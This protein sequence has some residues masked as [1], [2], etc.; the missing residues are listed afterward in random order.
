MN[1]REMKQTYRCSW[2]DTWGGRGAVPRQAETWRRTLWVL[3]SPLAF[4]SRFFRFE[5]I[6]I[7]LANP[8]GVSNNKL[9][10]SAILGCGAHDGAIR[11]GYLF[12]CLSRAHDAYTTI[13]V[14]IFQ[15]LVS[16]TWT[17]PTMEGSDDATHIH[18]RSKVTLVS[19]SS[20]VGVVTSH[21]VYGNWLSPSST[22]KRIKR[23]A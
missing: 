14:N 13:A 15:T 1:E 18:Q 19:G 10:L 11:A 3:A 5:W 4:E 9:G 12:H 22:T 23:S 7:R 16:V 8:R 6:G 20:P 21:A 17:R 2:W